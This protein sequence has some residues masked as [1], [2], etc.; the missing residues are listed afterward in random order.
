MHASTW[1]KRHWRQHD[2]TWL[3]TTTFNMTHPGAK[4]QSEQ[5]EGDTD[6]KGDSHPIVSQSR[7]AAHECR[8]HRLNCGELDV[9]LRADA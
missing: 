2:A 3:L 1:I 9:G 4:R 5:E 8:D 6:G 7:H